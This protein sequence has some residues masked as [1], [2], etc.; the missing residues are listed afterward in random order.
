MN[1]FVH[2]R[3]HVIYKEIPEPEVTKGKVKI[4][5]KAAGLNHRDLNIP[6]RRGD[7][8]KPLVLGSDGA[9][10]IE[11]IGPEVTN[12]SIGDEVIV[13]PGL[14]WKHTSDAPPEGFEI[15]GMPDHGTFAEKIVIDAE[16]VERKPA[17]MNW[18]EAG[19]LALS[20]L[21]GYRALFTKAKLKA[22]ETILIPGAGSGVATFIIQF[23][24]A[25]GAR[26]IVTSRDEEKCRKALDIGADKAIA[27]NSNWEEELN[28]E[29]IDLVIESVG[30]ATFNRS[31]S[32]LKR[33]GKIVTFGATTDDNVTINI[34]QFFYGQYQ[35]LGSTMGSREELQAMLQF[36]NQYKIKP[37]V[38]HVFPLSHT[39]E[40]FDYLRHGKQFGKVAI[41]V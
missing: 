17:F 32:V 35:L 34:R 39:E 24:K 2:E 37:V 11:E 9:G 10:V 19:V 23:A 31:L 33:G 16:H 13:N 5:L 30:N 7:N 8:E 38:D 29:Q 4:K 1:A 36:V 40:A 27:T 3:E 28:D 26:V 25:A 21:T 14:G 6:S 20:A 18:E 15:L 41:I 22:G 12:L